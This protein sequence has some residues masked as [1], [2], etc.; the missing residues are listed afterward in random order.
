MALKGLSSTKIV[1]E[2]WRGVKSQKNVGHHD[3]LMEKMLGFQWPKTS[4]IV[5]SFLCFLWK[6]FKYVQDFSCSSK[7]FLQTF[8]FLHGIFFIKIQKITK[9]SVQNETLQTLHKLRY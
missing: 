4:Q 7:Q 6:I 9:R 5:L 8:F 1:R 3:W 2:R